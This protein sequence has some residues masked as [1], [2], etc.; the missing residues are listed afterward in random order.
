MKVRLKIEVD[1][2]IDMY[3]INRQEDCDSLASA[4]RTEFEIARTK[5]LNGEDYESDQIFSTTVVPQ[6]WGHT[7]SV[8]KV[9]D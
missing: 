7:F 2:E 8:K 4:I 5:M 6:E 3:Q 9:D 1:V